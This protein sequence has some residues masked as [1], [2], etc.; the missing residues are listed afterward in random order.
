[1]PNLYIKLNHSYV[2]IGRN[3]VHIV[4]S[5]LYSFRHPLGVL[6]MSLQIRGD[7]CIE[8]FILVSV[9]FLLNR[10]KENDFLLPSCFPK[11]LALDSFGDN[12]RDV[13][14]L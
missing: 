9:C 2:Y 10:L 6:N 4:F 14:I 3:I 11:H 7:Y 12:F 5:I 1:M 13:R 8:V